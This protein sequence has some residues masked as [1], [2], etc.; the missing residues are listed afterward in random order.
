MSRNRKRL[1]VTLRT[2]KALKIP[3]GKADIERSHRIT[4]RQSE[5]DDG[6]PRRAPRAIIVKFVSYRMRQSV[7][8][9]RRKLAGQ[10]KSI[11]EDL[12]S[13]YAKLLKDTKKLCTSRRCLD[14]RRPHHCVG[15]E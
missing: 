2:K 3:V 13:A 4:P 11:Q 5:E 15:Q 6:G 14:E 1:G 9:M 10:R 7:L 8:K 12:T